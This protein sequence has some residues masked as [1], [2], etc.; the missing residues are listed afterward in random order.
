MLNQLSI[1]NY[2]LIENQKIDF[3]KGFSVI[4]GE[5]G[6]GKSIILGALGLLLGDRADKEVV[7]EGASK[8]IVEGHFD[9]TNLNTKSFFK[10][11]DLDFEEVSII[12]REVNKNGKSRAFIN[13]TPVTLQI[14]KQFALLLMDIH[15]QNQNEQLNSSEYRLSIIDSYANHDLLLKEYRKLF[16]EFTNST[17]SLEDLKSELRDQKNEQEYHQFLFDELEAL[18]LNSGEQTDL[19]EELNLLNHAEEIKSAVYQVSSFL[20]SS[21]ENII[22]KLETGQYS[23]DKVSDYLELAKSISERINSVTIELKDIADELSSLENDIHFDQKRLNEVE[24]RLNDIYS[25]NRKH[26]KNNS[27]E[28]IGLKEELSSKIYGISELED[29]IKDLETTLQ[30]QLDELKKIADELNR[31]RK[32]ASSKIENLV[33]ELLKELGLKNA[34]LELQINKNNKLSYSGWDDT[35]FLFSANKGA[36]L[37][38]MKKVASGGEM[39]RLMLA[40]KYVMALKKSLPSIIF[41]EI[42]SGVSGEIADKLAALMEKLGQQIQVISITHL[43]QVAARANAHYLV[44]KE[45]ESK[46]AR[47]KIEKLN[48]QQ[49]LHEIAGMLSGSQIEESAIKHA[50][51]LLRLN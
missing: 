25:L 14:L 20:S 8:C 7:M 11:N 51:K 40:F 39:S 42:D 22:E 19:E 35:K 5:T 41:D 16:V 13:D 36:K 31:N 28:L 23:L 12:R 27:D 15:S 21:E 45:N 26:G 24:E 29:K 33:I 6:A 34:T 37:A 50:E 17:A 38:E 46:F 47:S 49:R 4:T 30:K 9:I 48:S 2:V 18:K 43:P 1:K 10:E 32:N 3:Q 44:Y